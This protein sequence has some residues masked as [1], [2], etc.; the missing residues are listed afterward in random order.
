MIAGT[1]TL[2][3]LKVEQ[4]F[5]NHT[6][7]LSGSN[8]CINAAVTFSF[9]RTEAVTD[10]GSMGSHFVC[11]CYVLR[12]CVYSADHRTKGNESY[13]SFSDFKSGVSSIVA[14]RLGNPWTEAFKQRACRMCTCI[15]GHYSCTATLK[16]S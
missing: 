6:M 1:K 11:R 4:A 3:Y 15:C 9:R 12:C 16:S 8:L 5:L 7:L 13:G 14:C 10:S 2:L